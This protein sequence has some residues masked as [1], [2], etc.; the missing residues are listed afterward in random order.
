MWFGVI[1]LFPEMFN[2]VTQCGVTRRACENGLIEVHCFNPRDYTHDKYQ[3]V[4]DKPYGGGPGMLMKV[5]PLTDAI[6]AARQQAPSGTK[7]VCMSPQGRKLDHSLVTRFH[8][9]GSMILVAGRYE[10]IDERVLQTEVDLEVSIGDYVLSGG[11]L[12]AMCIIDAVAR[13][14][15]GVLGDIRNAQEDT[16]AQGLLHFPQYTRPEVVNGLGVPEVLMSGDHA[17]IRLWRLQQALGRTMMRRPDLLENK[18]L[19]SEEL[20]LLQQYLQQKK[21]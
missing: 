17:K 4:D 12:P 2:A 19:S 5:Q 6:E 15:P 3:T 16:F 8:S 21:C 20:S 11:E 7:V 13:M 1:S 18:V 14:V 10:G 9:W